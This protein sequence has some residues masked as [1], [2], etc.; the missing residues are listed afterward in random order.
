[1]AEKSKVLEEYC[2]VCCGH[3]CTSDSKCFGY[4]FLNN[5]ILDDEYFKCIEE[6]VDNSGVK[7]KAGKPMMRL[8]L[9]HAAEALVRIREYGLK[10]YPNADNWK[11]V[12]KE[13]WLDAMLRHMMKYLDGEEIDFESGKPHLWHALCNLSYLVEMDCIERKNREVWTAGTIDDNS[14]GGVKND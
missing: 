9:P 4:T 14:P 5:K 7:D 13:D 10:K 1:M 6:V 12:P 11:S 2:K 3:E 8:I